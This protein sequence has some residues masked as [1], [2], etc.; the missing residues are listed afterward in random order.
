MTDLSL[1]TGRFI[2]DEVGLTGPGAGG[3]VGREEEENKRGG[4]C[5]GVYYEPETM[6]GRMSDRLWFWKTLGVVGP[7]GRGDEC[8]V[9]VHA[10]PP[11]PRGVR[12]RPV[13]PHEGAQ[14]AEVGLLL[15]PG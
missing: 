14:E 5:T 12:Q 11:P 4:G 2:L 9:P 13:C 7:R 10:A 6:G 8:D 15:V 3:E 1:R